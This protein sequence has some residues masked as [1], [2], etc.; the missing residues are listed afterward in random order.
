M[1]QIACYWEGLE[2]LC[3]SN[4]SIPIKQ[5]QIVDFLNKLYVAFDSIIEK[6]NVYKVWSV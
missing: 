4:I 2:Y 3:T 5:I 6:R 1:Q